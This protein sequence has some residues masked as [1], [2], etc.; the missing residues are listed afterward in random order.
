MYYAAPDASAAWA[1]TKALLAS[2][3]ED[4]GTALWKSHLPQSIEPLA[5]RQK[6]DVQKTRSSGVKLAQQLATT[7]DSLSSD[8][9]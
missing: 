6:M 8:E 5:K 3:L 7:A 9:F 2:D 4:H 1:L